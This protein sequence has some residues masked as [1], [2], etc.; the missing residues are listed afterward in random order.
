VVKKLADTFVAW[1]VQIAVSV[2]DIRRAYKHCRRLGLIP[3]LEPE[4]EEDLVLF[5]VLIP[6]RAKRN[7]PQAIGKEMKLYGMHIRCMER[8]VLIRPLARS[9][10]R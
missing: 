8:V 4:F 1:K 7:S 5:S 6:I 3:E 2:D 9:Q 10:K